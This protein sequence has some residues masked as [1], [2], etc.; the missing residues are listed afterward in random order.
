MERIGGN[1]N[2]WRQSGINGEPILWDKG[3]YYKVEGEGIL[4]PRF[5]LSFPP[6]TQLIWSI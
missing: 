6:K 5:A 1:R 2:W 4:K 3:D